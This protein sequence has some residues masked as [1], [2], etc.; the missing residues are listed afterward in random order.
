MNVGH[1][2]A[3]YQP[4]QLEGSLASAFT[5]VVRYLRDFNE[6]AHVEQAGEVLYHLLR[7][8]LWFK[9]P[10]STWTLLKKIAWSYAAHR[11]IVYSGWVMERVLPYILYRNYPKLLARWCYLDR[12]KNHTNLSTLRQESEAYF[13]KVIIF[14]RWPGHYYLHLSFLECVG[15]TTMAFLSVQLAVFGVFLLGPLIIAT[16]HAF[17]HSLGCHPRCTGS[18]KCSDCLYT[19][20]SMYSPTSPWPRYRYTGYDPRE[21]TDPLWNIDADEA[22]AMIARRDARLSGRADFM[23]RSKTDEAYGF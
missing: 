10:S 15:L 4:A 23:F 11:L 19:S 22:A 3:S 12:C 16:A 20:K 17:Q 13:H 21:E 9:S 1:F 18:T 5:M 2:G 8:C 14:L 6:I 7:I